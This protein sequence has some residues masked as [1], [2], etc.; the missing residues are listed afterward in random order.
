MNTD[1]ETIKKHILKLLEEFGEP[2]STEVICSKLNISRDIASAAL[3]SLLRQGFVKRLYSENY[4]PTRPFDTASWALSKARVSEGKYEEVCPFLCNMR[5]VLSVPQFLKTLRVK[6]LNILNN[7][8]ALD[9]HDAY[10]YVIDTATRE[11]KI[12]CPIIDIYVLFPLISKISKSDNIIV[13]ILTEYDRSENIIQLFA[14]WDLRNVEIRNGAK[15]FA[16]DNTRRKIFGIHAKLMI[17]D[18]IVA[19]IGTFNFSMYHYLVNFDMGFLI[20]DQQ[21]VRDL[22]QIF[23]LLWEHVSQFNR[24]PNIY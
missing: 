9:L 16:I 21:V 20:Y 3:Y 11:L 6:I 4:D 2:L 17:A 10:K 1:V 18:D 15:Y 12:M 24:S 5:L 13:K 8:E 23:D 19:L 7:Y 22:S 14:N